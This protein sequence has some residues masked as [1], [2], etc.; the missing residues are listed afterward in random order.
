MDISKFLMFLKGIIRLNWHL[1]KRFFLLQSIYK[2]LFSHNG[3]VWQ[4]SWAHPK[5]G[6]I[7]ASCGF[8]KKVCI[9]KET[10]VNEWALIISHSE[11]QGSGIYSK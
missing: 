6:N 4:I 11:H 10:K 1:L 7:I 2:Q 5:F 3:P 9:W 8:D